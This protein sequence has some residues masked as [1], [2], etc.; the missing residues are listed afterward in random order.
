[1]FLINVLD[2]RV[3]N[4]INKDYK[5]I[6]R[7]NPDINKILYTSSNKFKVMLYNEEK[8][9]ITLS[10]SHIFEQQISKKTHL[11]VYDKI[12]KFYDGKIHLQQEHPYEVIA[13]IISYIVMTK[14]STQQESIIYN[15]LTTN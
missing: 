9:P 6:K 1:L 2:L 8:H 4:L 7:S 14:E 5:D 11:N 3:H 15:W 10:D 13:C 12:V